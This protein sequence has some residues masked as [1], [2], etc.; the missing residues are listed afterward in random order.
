[1][2]AGFWYNT[3]MNLNPRKK[4][5][6]YLDYAGT[7]PL[8][9]KV[10]A[11]MKPFLT[12]EYGN[13]SS[14]YYDGVQAKFAVEEARKKISKVLNSKDSEIVF[15]AG[16][17]ESDNMAVFGV[18]RQY[19]TNNKRKPHIVISSIE[20]HAILEPVK[21]LEQE[22]V[23][24]TYLPVDSEGFVNPKQLVKALKPNTVL[25]SI[26][27]AN[28]E[29]GTIQPISEL[30][31]AV[32]K[33]NPK[34]LF[35]TDACQAAG[36]LNLDVNK[37]GVDLMTLNGSKIYGPKQTGLLYIRS[38]VSIKPLIYGGGQERGLRSGTENVA[39]IVGFAEAL[40]IAEKNKEK[41]N[42]RLR[43]LR[44]YFTTKALKAIP[45]LLL[46]GPDVKEDSEKNS[47]RLPNNIS[48]TVLGAEGE[49]ILLYLDAQG[50]EVSTGSACASTSLDASHVLTAIGR[51]EKDAR[52][53]VRFTLGR[54]T[55]K[56]EL[57]FTLKVLPGIV[58]ELR[59]VEQ[60]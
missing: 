52:S 15:T 21:A 54:E 8:D 10:F 51:K 12:T 50:I 48:F 24:V 33:Y 13:P 4:K 6:I 17:T 26:I 36:V 1:M 40:E 53:A 60:L 22:G 57:D 49:A 16:G 32:K 38:G 55:T 18:V 46:N 35:H 28:N 29:I 23:E 27:Y 34:I 45:N 59:R 9:P 19:F 5:S 3:H 20:H 42:K 14:L 43:E 39:G 58:K 31:R 44:N 2:L 47:V 7:T 25:V 37:L 41:E 11:V 56:K 30:S